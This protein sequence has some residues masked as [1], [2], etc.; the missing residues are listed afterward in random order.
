MA[1][2]FKVKAL[3]DFEAKEEDDLGFSGGQIIDV[4][5][6]VDDN[7]LE[8]K[9]TDSAGETQSGI[10]PRDFAEKYEPEV[11]VRPSRPARAK[12]EAVPTPAPVPAPAPTAEPEVQHEDPPSPPIQSKPQPPPVAIPAASSRESEEVRSPPSAS[13]QQAPPP[14]AR[15]DPPPAPKPAAAEPASAK[16]PPPVAAKSN[17]F[18][19]RIAAFNQGGAAPVAPMA[20]GGKPQSNTF[21][22]KPFVAPP[23]MSNSYVPPPKVE[24][25]H[26]PYIREEDPEIKR[27]REEDHAAA[28]SAGLTNDAPAEQQEEGEEAPKAQ[29]LK[30]RIARLQQQQMEQAQRRAEG[31]GPRKEKKAPIKQHSESSEQAALEEAEAEPE[32]LER[33]RSPATERQSLDI[34][35]ERPRVPSAQRP[36]EAPL[37]PI[38]TAPEHEL[39]SD[40]NEA[41]QSA[42]GETT[43]DDA[44][45]IGPDD[46]DDRHAPPPPPRAVAAPKQQPDVGD[47]EDPEE[48]EEDEDSMDEETRRRLELRERMAKMSGGMGM[49]GMFGPPGGM[50]MPGVAK[51]KSTKERKTSEEIA[52]SS[53]PPQQRI[54]MVPMPGIQKVQSPETQPEPEREDPMTEEDDNPL[55]PP[56][57]STGEDVSSAPPVPKGKKTRNSHVINHTN[58]RGG[59]ID[60]QHSAQGNHTSYPSSSDGGMDVFTKSLKMSRRLSVNAQH[61]HC[62]I[63]TCLRRLHP[64]TAVQ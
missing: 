53:P 56:R 15:N 13:S 5:E 51:K 59:K 35:R 60:S 36:R 29:S 62:P 10:F 44:G 64:L 31:S 57:R 6:V 54:P 40:G 50:P 46:S 48:D 61:I 18:R 1:S 4:T 39:V 30:E 7:W 9:Y 58:V 22:R 34:S 33:V 3:Y 63:T 21:I 55:P 37:S 8:G 26:K 45:T 11:P 19:D 27:R 20:P 52:P 49:A 43:E 47:E 24:T 41:D 14:P 28:E 17:A 2:L 32:D 38:A 12:Q 25:V 42:A 16:K 23:P